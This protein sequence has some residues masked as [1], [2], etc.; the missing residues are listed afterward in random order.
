M[1]G[2]HGLI[3]ASLRIRRIIDDHQ[4]TSR[5]SS[6]CHQGPHQGSSRHHEDIIKASSGHH[7]GIIK[8]QHEPLELP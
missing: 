1:D 8:A 3:M 7:Q 2:E 6:G 5:A 4:R